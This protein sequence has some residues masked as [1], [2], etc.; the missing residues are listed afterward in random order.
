MI[1]LQLFIINNNSM[2]AEVSLVIPSHNSENGLNELLKGMIHWSLL[3]TEVLVIDSSNSKPTISIPFQEFCNEKKISFKLISK[4]NLFPGKARNIGIQKACFSH[5]AFL[6]I[7]TIP[8]RDWFESTMKSLNYDNFDGVWGSTIYEAKSWFHKLIR[9]ATFGNLPLQTLPGSI[10]HKEV[11]ETAGLFIESTRAG[12]DADW[13]SRARLHKFNF[14]KS[15]TNLNYIGLSNITFLALIKKWYRNYTYSAKLP[16]LNAHKDLY[17]YFFAFIAV[18]LAF[19]W[20]NLSYDDAI[21]GWNTESFAYIP[22]I[23]KI[24]IIFFSFF[25]I[26][27]RAILIPIKKGVP[28]LFL[29]LNI[30]MIV[31][32]SIILDIVKS[33]AFINAR[34]FKFNQIK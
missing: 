5:I 28:F 29:F 2:N 3:P 10:I 14:T 4:T 13:M 32:L 34:F 26:F 30:P 11:F 16:Y 20:N 15:L 21:R 19:N 17:F 31:F 1:V 18:I 8:P 33:A 9:S 22:N 24:S 12:E 7:S 23:T 27:I 25:Y 6:D